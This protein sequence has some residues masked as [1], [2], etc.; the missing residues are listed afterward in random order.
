L[1]AGLW[2]LVA[3]PS[4]RVAEVYRSRL[5]KCIFTRHG[6][7]LPHAT[8]QTAGSKRYVI[9]VRVGC[10]HGSFV[11]DDAPVTTLVNNK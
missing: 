3:C 11:Q 7:K 5:T 10:M 6:P 4:K 1:G 9:G 8:G 2:P